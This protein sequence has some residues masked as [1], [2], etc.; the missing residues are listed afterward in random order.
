MLCEGPG[1]RRTIKLMNDEPLRGLSKQGARTRPGENHKNLST[2][3]AL[4]QARQKL[5]GLA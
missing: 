1:G 2:S 4:M 5:N 3:E